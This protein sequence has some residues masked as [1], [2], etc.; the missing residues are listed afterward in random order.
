MR[1]AACGKLGARSERPERGDPPGAP[2]LRNDFGSHFHQVGRKPG[3]GAI[4]S[5]PERSGG[6]SGILLPSE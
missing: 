1:D 3:Y 2:L 5:P 6:P 4:V